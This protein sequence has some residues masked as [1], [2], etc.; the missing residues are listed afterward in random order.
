M[1]LTREERSE[2]SKR[3]W[4]SMTDEERAERGRKISDAKK[5]FYA[6]NPEWGVAQSERM[7][8]HHA[9]HP[10]TGRSVSEGMKRYWAAVNAEQ[11][12]LH[13]QKLRV[14]AKKGGART[15]EVRAAARAA[16]EAGKP[17]EREQRRIDGR[18]DAT[19]AGRAAKNRLNGEVRTQ[20]KLAKADHA[21][22]VISLAETVNDEQFRA[23]IKA[24]KQR[25]MEGE[26]RI[27]AWM[28]ANDML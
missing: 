2:R 16:R 17:R 21:R 1:R 12:E 8:R 15:A 6:Q 20:I 26:K 24:Q 28:I 25:E 4:A 14:S 11:R 3:A 27:R 19:A 22:E 10:E 9:E 5:R 18:V 13:V 23:A 7:K